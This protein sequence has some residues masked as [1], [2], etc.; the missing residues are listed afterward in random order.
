VASL[1]GP[2]A[3]LFDEFQMGVPIARRATIDGHWGSIAG[4]ERTEVQ[5]AL[6][7]VGR[8]STVRVDALWRGSVVARTSPANA[9][10]RQVR[11]AW[12]DSDGIDS[13]IVTALGSLPEDPAA[14]ERERR[15]R[16]LGRVRAAFDHPAA[17]TDAWFDDWLQRIGAQSVGDL[18]ARFRGQ[19]LT[20]ALQIAFADPAET[21]PSPKAL[22]LSAA[23][24]I[25]DAP[26][27]IADLLAESK[28]IREQLLEAGVER[29]RDQ[30]MS[31]RAPLVV[32][33]I[34]P[35][36]IFDDADWP[37]GDVAGRRRTAAA[38]LGAE[39]IA[40]AALPKHPA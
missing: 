33:W 28:M 35:S 17:F 38:W 31:R 32:V 1:S 14:L 26:L 20:G 12:P 22:P 37:G 6:A 9:R 13:E 16:F 3:G 36:S 34:V 11:S 29:A 21:P 25:R 23:I 5:L 24:L 40:V 2:Y 4:M 39:G 10:I 30:S 7:G 15:T 18:M 8:A 19:L 27:S